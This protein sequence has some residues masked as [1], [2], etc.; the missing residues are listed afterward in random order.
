MLRRF[1]SSAFWSSVRSCLTG[2]LLALSAIPTAAQ[3]PNGLARNGVSLRVH[4]VRPGGGPAPGVR[5]RLSSAG[6]PALEEFS[7]DSGQVLF[8]GLSPGTYHA[9]ASAEGYA[10]ADSGSFEVDARAMGQSQFLRLRPKPESG[11]WKMLSGREGVVGVS[12]LGVPRNAIQELHKANA[13]MERQEWKKA[14]EHLN[15]AVARY[16]GFAAAYNN[17]GVAYAHLGD[18]DH[19]RQMLDQALKL[20]DRNAT[21]L[22]NRAH[23]AIQDHDLAGAEGYLTRA[24]ALDPQNVQALMVLAKVQL[25]ARHY[26][27]A[28]MSARKVHTLPHQQ[29]PIV[30]YL[31]ARA[32]ESRNQLQDAAAEL[33]LFLQEEP[34]GQWSDAARKEL[35]LL[36]AG[37]V[38]DT[39]AELR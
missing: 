17:L 8:N 7:D 6:S 38:P 39:E 25:F 32:C 27:A 34:H 19:E 36:E 10:D 16:P 33:R 15:K 12:T 5:V 24:T 18:R 4:V 21:A 11:G 28:L 22:M 20:N 30:H 26:D 2:I 23:V 13:L 31:A 14:V 3:M 29:Y 1:C 35:G 37:S 9:V